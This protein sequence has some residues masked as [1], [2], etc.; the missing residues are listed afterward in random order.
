MRSILGLL[1]SLLSPL[2]VPVM[3]LFRTLFFRAQVSKTRN[4]PELENSKSSYKLE[5]QPDGVPGWKGRAAQ[6]TVASVPGST[7]EC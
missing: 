7:V 3:A 5:L 1:P 4:W 2:L 6:G